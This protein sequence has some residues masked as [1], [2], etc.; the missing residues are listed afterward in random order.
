MA[1]VREKEEK[2]DIALMGLYTMCETAGLSILEIDIRFGKRKI[3]NRR[4]RCVH[5]FP[6]QRDQRDGH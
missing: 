1:S 4:E 2:M 3:E 6:Y 5:T